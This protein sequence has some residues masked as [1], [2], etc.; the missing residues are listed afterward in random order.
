MSKQST[1]IFIWLQVVLLLKKNR[2]ASGSITGSSYYENAFQINDY[3][4]FHQQHRHKTWNKLVFGVQ[5]PFCKSPDIA[6]SKLEVS[7]TVRLFGGDSSH[8]LFLWFKKFSKKPF[9]IIIQMGQ[10][11][12]LDFHKKSDRNLFSL[13]NLGII[14]NGVSTQHF[15]LEDG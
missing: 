6:M 12:L 14:F 15:P 9:V 7:A 4:W 8:T 13:G 11:H 1:H 3:L 10:I 2:V 5:P